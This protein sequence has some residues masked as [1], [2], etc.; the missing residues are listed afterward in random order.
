MAD[1]W[2]DVVTPKDAL[3]V[4]CLL[5]A[6]HKKKL[7]VLVTAKEQT[8]TTQIL[9]IL[10]IPYVQI[11]S[12]GNTL[13]EKLVEEQKRILGFVD[14]FEETGTPRALWTHGGVD[15]VRTAFGLQIP[16]VYS[17]D[18]L[19]ATHVAR[20]VSPLVDWLIAPKP[21]GKSWSKFG[22]P[23]SRIKLY[24]GV[25]EVAWI[26][27]AATCARS[28][29]V[30]PEIEELSKSG[31]LILFRDVE[32]R[33]SYFRELEIDTFRLLNKLSK[34]AK[35]VCLPRYEEERKE[36]EKIENVW[37]PEKTILAY[38]LLPAVD[39]VVGSGGTVCRESA[40]LGIPTIS[41]HFWDVIARYLH[42]KGFPLCYTAKEDR[43][44]T[45]AK[46]SLKNT[47]IH[48]REATNR[49]RALESPIPLT[50]EYLR[51]VCP[52][53]NRARADAK[54]HY[55]DSSKSTLIGS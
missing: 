5:P 20:L 37:V 17:N 21:F 25:E 10:D 49:L 16:I 7:D 19:H 52:P 38:H 35:V 29:K 4:Y 23:R 24:D 54:C 36:L 8:Q 51:R 2:L 14:L 48:K 45:L 42:K 44:V 27:S 43:I 41:F 34:M 39:L 15:A 55:S 50:V 33:A 22:I 12:Y 11:G 18:T 53:G 3:L 1:V 9:Q 30:P 46:A 32:H 47:E 40:L 31:P 13:K 6:L 26:K 28:P